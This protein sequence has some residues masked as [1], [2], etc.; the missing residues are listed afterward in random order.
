[1][2]QRTTTG[3]L[4]GR[5]FRHLLGALLCLV[6][7]T[8]LL[9]SAGTVVFQLQ[10]Q[11]ATDAPPPEPATA[12][13]ERFWKGQ[14]KTRL[15]VELSSPSLAEIYSLRSGFDSDVGYFGAVAPDLQSYAVFLREERTAF[16][17]NV[18]ADL[19]VQISRYISG[20][21][22]AADELA[23]DLVKNAVILEATEEL[24]PVQLQTLEALPQVKYV[25]P[26]LPVYPQLYAGSSLI[27]VDA[28]W[29]RAPGGRVRAGQGVLIASIDG[30]LHKDAPMF[31][32]TG[33]EYPAWMPRE[34]L[35]IT[36]A[37][38]GKIVVS[39]TY[40][41]E[42]D[43]P[44]ASDH[45]PWPGSGT[46]HGVH[47]GAIAGGN[48]VDGA[49]WDGL[50]L[51]PLS[52]IAPGAWLGSY[53]VL[54]RSRQG[55]QTF[56]TAEGVQALEDVVVDGA[57][58]AVGAW[59]IGPSTVS[60]PNDFLDSALVNV[61]R[62]G[63]YVVMAA[64]NYGPLPFSVANPS[65]AYLS[66]GAVTTTGFL[67]DGYL[68]VAD[69]AEPDEMLSRLRFVPARFGPDFPQGTRTAYPLV[70]GYALNAANAQ[71]CRSWEPGSLD[72]SMLLVSRGLCTFAE[73][74]A[75]ASQ[76]GAA[77]VIVSNH[78]AG[79]DQL[80]EMVK[81]PAEFETPLPS[82]FVSHGSG[83]LL[84]MLSARTGRHL[85]VHVSTVPEQVGNQPFQVPDFSGRGP[86]VY[87]GLK[88]D[89]VAPGVHILS[90]GYGAGDLDSQRHTGYG[91]E[92]GT[93]MAAPFVAGAVALIKERHPHWTAD[94]ITS[95]LMSTAQYEGIHNS[96]GSVAQPTDMGAGLVDVERALDPAAFLVPAKISFG[97]VRSLQDIR[98]RDLE[99]INAGDAPLV[100][101]LSVEKLGNSGKTPLDAFHVEPPLLSLAPRAKAKVT[102]MLQP[103]L[104]E[105]PTGYAQGYLVLR[106]E[107]QELHAPL[108]AWLDLPTAAP[109]LLLLD[110][111][112]SPAYPDYGRQYAAVLDE[113]EISYG[114]WDAAR[115]EHKIPAYV[116]SRAAP[117]TIL[118]FT[119]DGHRARTRAT[120]VPL[121]FAPHD[122]QRLANYVARGGSLLV[123]G[124]NAA[125]FVAS[126][127]LQAYLMSTAEA[128]LSSASTAATSTLMVRSS[129]EAPAWLQGLQL[130][131]RTAP[132]ML[133]EIELQ[134]AA[135][136]PP[137]EIAVPDLRARATFS[138]STRAGFLA[139]DLALEA[140]AGTVVSDA[141]FYIV[142][143]GARTRV[144]DL[145]PRAHRLPVFGTWDWHGQLE[146]SQPLEAAR[147]QGQLHIALQ[148][149]GA[150]PVTLSGQVVS[151]PLS[152]A[153]SLPDGPL[154]SLTTA[155]G[156][157][158]QAPFLILSADGYGGPSV[159]GIASDLSQDPAYTSSHGRT[160]FTTFGLER[161]RETA[162]HTSRA[163][164]LQ[165]VLLFLE[166]KTVAPD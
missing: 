157:E 30:G 49:V 65:D 89:V 92:T 99:V 35:G 126:A 152:A 63:V 127:P 90:Q 8:G 138:R 131:L 42:W 20:D 149:Q 13:P 93:S 100:L 36:Q 112:L 14:T 19:P 84:E 147:S 21:G 71:G 141:W 58:I 160:V 133:G 45:L 132:Q 130:D 3:F 115:Q 166:A 121:P 72:E 41:R 38:N 37:N 159:L 107:T 50:A 61:A 106:G 135:D 40:F 18:P 9:W 51:D 111:D 52:G 110:A 56:F 34:G 67:W 105:S 86:T 88:P 104:A 15:I 123:M 120:T 53:R 161:I 29:Q 4:P 118:L 6:T 12:A 129:P 66:V 146:L 87:G 85:L 22:E 113:L 68:D 91:Q 24:T 145:L 25:H 32:G 140:P 39:R 70:S 78:A 94:M 102:V 74:V 79:G 16:G 155:P 164:F 81:G 7:A 76:A 73:K 95:A 28:P 77:A 137:A 26:D 11:S 124:R 151:P 158:G 48:I 27:R 82:L 108:F 103:E 44:V 2:T 142:Q 122:L 62:A 57:D 136:G 23:F 154:Y 80:L 144:K 128:R 134:P 69:A 5:R 97:R 83:R 163:H 64:G 60:A 156:P 17:L 1:M 31:A 98:P 55:S 33:F 165:Q 54:Y 139:Y 109:E 59:G 10:A 101:H 162:A 125:D 119:G 153:G 46:S 116:D 114:Y 96:D 47:T 150:T 43:P 117:K 75:H 143:D 148:L